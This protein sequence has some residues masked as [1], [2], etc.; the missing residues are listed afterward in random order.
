ME[1]DLADDVRRDDRERKDVCEVFGQFNGVHAC[2]LAASELGQLAERLEIALVA[3]DGY[4]VDSDALRLGILAN[5]LVEFLN[6]GKI[7]ISLGLIERTNADVSETISADDDLRAGSALSSHGNRGSDGR[8][9]GRRAGLLELHEFALKSLR[10]IL[11]GQLHPLL[12]LAVSILNQVVIVV[13]L[14]ASNDLRVLC[15]IAVD[16]DLMVEADDSELAIACT[17]GHVGNLPVNGGLKA[18][19]ARHV[20]HVALALQELIRAIAEPHQ[21]LH[22]FRPVT[23]DLMLATDGLRYTHR[24]GLVDAE[25]YRDVFLAA[26]FRLHCLS[27][28]LHDVVDRGSLWL[29][30]LLEVDLI[31]VYAELASPNLLLFF[32]DSFHRDCTVHVQDSAA[33]CA[34]CC[35]A[36]GELR[37]VPQRCEVNLEHVRVDL[38]LVL[39]PRRLFPRS[40]LNV[41]LYTHLRLVLVRAGV[42]VAL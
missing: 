14:V 8:S 26:V 41:P 2:D 25:D 5:L 7:C 27:G 21:F 22:F 35:I 33:L 24:T 36:G 10:R 38:L 30:L 16:R 31:I 37:L 28:T 32:T 9:K 11:D 19:H 39:T 42:E 3:S 13:K 1:L 20:R 23:L 29:L 15:S 40:L 17:V 34:E 18:L 12:S 4:D 6:F